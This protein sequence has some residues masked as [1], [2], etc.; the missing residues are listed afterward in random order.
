MRV[1]QSSY[2]IVYGSVISP[3]Q[4]EN[5][6]QW[7]FSGIVELHHRH[8][9]YL[10]HHKSINITHILLR[11]FSFK[12]WLKL[13]GLPRYWKGNFNGET[14]LKAIKRDLFFWLRTKFREKKSW[15]CS[16]EFFTLVFIPNMRVC[17]CVLKNME[18][19]SNLTS[20]L[21]KRRSSSD[22]LLL[23]PYMYIISYTHTRYMEKGMDDY[24]RNMPR[25]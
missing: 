17:V 12:L 10:C 22:L 7:F 1:W 24:L 6:P 4:H 19:H 2:G 3:P 14:T 23:Y 16:C 11:D 21:E 20:Y 9:H 18:S 5:Y 25:E 13:C 15:N 8:P